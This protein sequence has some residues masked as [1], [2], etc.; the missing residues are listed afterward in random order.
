MLASYPRAGPRGAIR[1]RGESEGG[2]T[3][4]EVARLPFEDP[5]REPRIHGEI[6][7]L[8]LYDVGYEIQLERAVELL[9]SSAPERTRPVRG[10]A[11]AI[12]IANPP[13]SVSLGSETITV[14]DESHDVD[15]TARVFDFGVVSLRARVA[16]RPG[17]TW[18]ELAACGDAW[19]STPDWSRIFGSAR[20]ALADR[21]APAIERRHDSQVSEDYVVFRV[22][23]LED[24]NGARLP[25]A[26]LPDEAIA[27]LLL[28]ESR[29]L[30]EASRR[31]LLSPR[32]SYF[33]D[34][35]TVLT[36]SSALV[37]EPVVEDTDV[38]YVL[39]FANA[40]LLELR[41]YDALLDSELPRT[42]DAIAEARRG[43][44][45]LGRNYNRVMAALQS[46]V[47]DTTEVVERAENALKMT[48]D[49]FLARIYSAT[50]EIFRARTWRSGIDRKIAIIRETYAMLNAETQARRVEVLEIVII[51]LI[52]LEIVLAL[53][54]H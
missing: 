44:H 40:Q 13:V 45:L 28:A 39:E 8:R 23:R 31:E 24:G 27:R 22:H 19:S 15:L 42:Y 41:L 35:V 46:R 50:L 53:L 48:N 38:Q 5:A 17:M 30:S 10:E 29:P 18:S 37:V 14:G 52:A 43:F 6:V 25:I 2:P 21:I 11:Q 16:V 34:D 1:R 12:Q 54:R 9:G 4:N 20:S 32:F 26:A 49:V 33:E 3:V 7:F 47:A 36:W 51:L